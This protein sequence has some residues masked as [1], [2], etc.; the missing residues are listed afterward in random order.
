M[1][2]S[3]VFSRDRRQGTSVSPASANSIA[4]FSFENL[5]DPDDPE[6]LGQIL[7]EL[8]ITDLSGLG[9]TRVLSSQ[10]LYDVQMQMGKK[11]EKLDRG[12]TTEVAVRAAGQQERGTLSP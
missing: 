12:L 6:R 3:V 2:T 5:K 1:S 7:Q 11:G 10:R 9:D 8:V 4:V